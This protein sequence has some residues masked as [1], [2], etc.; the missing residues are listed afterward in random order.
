MF[1]VNAGN[2]CAMV[3]EDTVYNDLEKLEGS[4]WG[5][6]TPWV[7][8]PVATYGNSRPVGIVLLGTYPTHYFC[9]RDLFSSVCRYIFT[10]NDFESFSS[11][12]PSFLEAFVT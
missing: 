7:N 1:H 6:Y 3:G 5:C 9:V 4:G 12:Y 10:S 11:R 8:N 2:F